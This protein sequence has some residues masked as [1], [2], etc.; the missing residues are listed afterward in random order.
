MA[1]YDA[2]KFK[3][4]HS[5][6]SRWSKVEKKYGVF[7]YFTMNWDQ[8]FEIFECIE[9]MWLESLISNASKCSNLS[10]ISMAGRKYDV[11]WYLRC[12]GNIDIKCFKM[13]KCI[14]LV[15]GTEKLWCILVSMLQNVSN[16]S[17]W[18]MT[19]RKWSL[20]NCSGL[21]WIETSMDGSFQ[22]NGIFWQSV[23]SC[24]IC[25]SGTLHKW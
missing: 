8:F 16:V 6:V 3:F 14:Q 7:W 4:K 20:L 10:K 15:H 23:S 17:K 24:Y 5:N 9:E 22:Q 18:S 12:T 21:H 13:Y 11:F 2:F 1:F 25:L 19:E